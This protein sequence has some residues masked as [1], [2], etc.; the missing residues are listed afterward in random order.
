MMLSELIHFQANDSKSNKEY[1]KNQPGC[2]RYSQ[3]SSI[4]TLG[5]SEYY[6]L[7]VI[8]KIV[9]QSQRLPWE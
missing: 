8:L 6:S 4:G 5:G 2:D 3:I 7:H 9:G 1:W